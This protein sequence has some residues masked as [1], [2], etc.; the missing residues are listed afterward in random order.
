[1]LKNS[2]T[3]RFNMERYFNVGIDACRISETWA[4]IQQN[5]AFLVHTFTDREIMY[6]D[7]LPEARQAESYAARWAAKEAAIKALGGL[8]VRRPFTD[9]YVLQEIRD[10]LI[11][12]PFI[13]LEGKARAKAERLGVSCR[14]PLSISHTGDYAIA[15]C[16]TL[17]EGMESYNMD[18]L[19]VI[20]LVQEAL[21]AC[22][23]R[24]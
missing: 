16:F 13:H 4:R 6:C 17:A 9:I 24:T 7:S 11:G 19:K 10:D 5:P 23:I 18:Q 12:M 15:V 20:A 2:A 1:M 8:G 22:K 21:N 3:I 14:M